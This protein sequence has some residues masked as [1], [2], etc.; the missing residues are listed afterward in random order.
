M[1]A[2]SI[3]H[4]SKRISRALV[5]FVAVT[6]LAGCGPAAPEAETSRMDSRVSFTDDELAVIRTLSPL[7]PL[8]PDPTNRY[9]DDPAAARLGHRLFYEPRLSAD[10]SIA[11]A[12]CHAYKRGFGD[13]G[14]LARGLGPLTRHSM[15]IWNVAYNEWFFWDGRVDTLWG[16]ALQ[17]LEEP[18]EHGTT[19]LGVVHTLHDDPVLCEEYEA[20]FGALPELDDETRFPPSGGPRDDDRAGIAAW[21]SMTEDDRHAVSAAFV[22]VGKAL[23]AYE[24]KLVSRRAPFDIFVEGLLDSDPEKLAALDE[25]A[26]RGLA[27]F[28]G[29][30]NCIECHA[31][32]TV[33]TG[34]FHSN[35]VPPT[36]GGEL[37]DAG[38]FDGVER[39]KQDDFKAAGPY[40]DAS[41]EARAAAL[42]KVE[43]L[44][45]EQKS[46]GTFKTPTLRNVAL[47]A[48]YMHE[49]QLATLE[50]VLRHYNTLEH[51]VFPDGHTDTSL[52]PLRLTD[53]ELADLKAF[54]HAL[55]DQAIDLALTVPLED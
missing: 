55:T 50:D 1:T 6:G 31:G 14:T 12:S 46:W 22:N 49:G 39:L 51:A 33:S 9:A 15:A 54:L 2:V 20:A 18:A 24:R 47:S 40:S 36:D 4:H 53:E 8:P 41:P 28:I 13:G 5:L 45:R 38:R 29:R 48:P 19:R 3:A 26:Q 17:P 16:Q 7:P 34:S 52:Q 30:A 44:V 27:L 32:P 23:A 11:C 35:G 37:T 43:S 10:G 25:P 21:A 42:E